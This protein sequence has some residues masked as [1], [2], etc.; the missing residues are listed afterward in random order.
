M[1]KIALTA[2]ALYATMLFA[3]ESFGGIGL[4]VQENNKSR[5]K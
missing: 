5:S 2:F 3:D 4:M 1:K